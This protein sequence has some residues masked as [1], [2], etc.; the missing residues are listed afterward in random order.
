MIVIVI[1]A[2]FGVLSA[3]LAY[4]SYQK[5][6]ILLLV[7]ALALFFFIGSGLLPG[8]L[9]SHL[10]PPRASL[11][12]HWGKKNGIILLGAGNVKDPRSH[13]ITPSFFSFSRIYDSLRLYLSCK[14]S[15]QECRI[16]PSGGDP[17]MTGKPE[18]I[19]YQEA[20]IDAGVKNSDII[21]ETHSNNTFQNAMYTS[22]ILKKH[23]FDRVFLITSGFHMRRASQYFSHFGINPVPEVSDYLAPMFSVIPKSYNFAITDLLLHEYIGIL[24]FHIANFLGKNPGISS[25]PALR[26]RG[27]NI[28]YHS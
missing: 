15:G 10:E 18:A 2:I 19:V 8:L 4:F 16:I 1:I 24:R 12:L 25:S 28:I 14:S 26:E 6:S 9:L 7:I 22:L 5:S 17:L 23:Q 27:G 3:L 11:P 13:S 21:P 20:L